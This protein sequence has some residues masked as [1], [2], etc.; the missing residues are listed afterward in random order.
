MHAQNLVKTSQLITTKDGS[1]TLWVPSLKETYHSTHGALQE[2]KHVF[3]E[4]GLLHW[5]KHHAGPSIKILEVGLGTGLN[6]LLTYLAL[7]TKPVETV[8]TGLEPYPVPWEYVPC[9]NYAAQL[10]QEQGCPITYEALQATFGLC[11]IQQE[12]S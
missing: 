7:L 11:S 12:T 4:H 3:I 10:T 1:H 2:S 6:V 5:L 9:F 8:Y